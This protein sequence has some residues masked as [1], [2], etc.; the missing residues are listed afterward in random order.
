MAATTI[1]ATE[2]ARNFSEVLNQVKYRGA[3]FD[4]VRGKDVVA[5]ITPAALASKLQVADLN[6]LFAGLPRLGRD[7]C[8]AFASDI[9]LARKRLRTPGGEWE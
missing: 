8:A 2:A 9:K 4:V 3:R 6:K 5:R 7:D 1:K